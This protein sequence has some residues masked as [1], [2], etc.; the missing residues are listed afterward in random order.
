M[1][2]ATYELDPPETA[3]RLAVLE[4]VGLA[5]G[6]AHARGRVL[7]VDGGTAVL[8]FPER[9][10]S[11]VTMLVSSLLAGEWADTA[12]FTRCRLVAI[13]WP[14][15][16][17][18]GPAFGASAGVT[19]GAIVKPSLGLS[20]REVAATAAGLARGGAHLVKDDEL[21]GDPAWCPLEERVRAVTDAIPPE[22]VYAPNVTGPVDS[23]LTRAEGAVELGAAAVMINVFA[24]GVDSL[25]LL[26]TADLGVPVFAHRV[27][28]ALWMR[29]AEVGVSTAVIAELTRLCGA[30]FVQVGSFTGQLFDGAEEVRAQI[31]ACRRDL[32]GGVRPS[33]AVVCGGVGP[34]NARAQVEQAGTDTG[35]MLLLGSA[36]YLHPGGIEHGVRATVEAI[37]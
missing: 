29:N 33:T 25:R 21:L 10:W 23:L 36:A 37:S 8:E 32:P 24:Q 4:S 2:R 13:D 30:D 15:S 16:M 31:D 7:E 26:R 22:V 1:I 19:V 3:E 20:P 27:G 11:D 14:A 28:A 12:A 5:E 6:P 34:E 18:P 9:N 35:L 17:F